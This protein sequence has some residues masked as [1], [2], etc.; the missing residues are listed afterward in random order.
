MVERLTVSCASLRTAVI[1]H[2]LVNIFVESERVEFELHRWD[3]SDH[4]PSK[5]DASL[6]VLDKVFH[7]LPSWCEKAVLIFL[8][9]LSPLLIGYRRN[10]L[11]KLPLDQWKKGLNAISQIIFPFYISRKH[12]LPLSDLGCSWARLL[13]RKASFLLEHHLSTL[14][15][16]SVCRSVVELSKPEVAPG[17]LKLK[18][19]VSKQLWG[20]F[21]R[22][23]Q[24]IRGQGQSYHLKPKVEGKIKP[25]AFSVGTAIWKTKQL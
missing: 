13:L 7:Q 10:T 4:S 18:K 17:W 9:P 20:E 3:L 12:V 15:H 8:I 24:Y 14:I 5:M 21:S 23:I 6:D 22:N 16:H 2:F 19:I 1:S 11:G 25:T